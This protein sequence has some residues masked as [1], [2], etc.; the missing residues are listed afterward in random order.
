MPI[1]RAKTRRTAFWRTTAGTMTTVSAASLTRHRAPGVRPEVAARFHPAP[2][3]SI[4]VCRL[5]RTAAKTA[6]VI[7]LKKAVF[8][9]S[10][11]HG[12]AAGSAKDLIVDWLNRLVLLSATEAMTSSAVTS[13]TR[14]RRILRIS[15]RT[16][17]KRP[18]A[19]RVL[20]EPRADGAGLVEPA[21]PAAAGGWEGTGADESAALVITGHLLPGR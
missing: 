17:V 3:C 4:S 14:R 8:S 7:A 2:L 9:N 15:T 6:P 10:I 18:G 21:I 11:A 13:S 20:R 19:V 1:M 5:A 12:L 16:D